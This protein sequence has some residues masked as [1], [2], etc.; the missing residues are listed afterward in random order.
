M[1]QHDEFIAWRPSATI[2][3]RSAHAVFASASSKRL[4]IRIALADYQESTMA[5]TF[6]FR[7]S[8]SF[9][10]T[11]KTAAPSLYVRSGLPFAVKNPGASHPFPAAGVRGHRAPSYL[12]RPASC[13]IG[14]RG[15]KDGIGQD[16]IRAVNGQGAQRRLREAARESSKLFKKRGL[17]W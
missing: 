13:D 4:H 3:R 12:P 17:A 9:V 8:M 5:R 2:Q 1:H 10:A 14:V 7:S 6:V 16:H 15:L 11:Q